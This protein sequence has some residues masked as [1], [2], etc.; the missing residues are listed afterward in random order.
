MPVDV[1]ILPQ[2]SG[3]PLAAPWRE[4][5]RLEDGRF[6]FQEERWRDFARQRARWALSGELLSAEIFLCLRGN[7]LAGRYDEHFIKALLEMARRH[8]WGDDI[9]LAV[10]WRNSIHR[11]QPIWRESLFK[12]FDAAIEH[13]ATDV[14]EEQIAADGF[15]ETDGDALSHG[16]K[17]S[18]RRHRALPL[19]AAQGEWKLVLP[20]TLSQEN[21]QALLGSFVH[22]GAEWREGTKLIAVV[23]Q[24]DP[25]VQSG[26]VRMWL[27]R[28]RRAPIVVA[29]SGYGVTPSRKLE[30]RCRAEDLELIEARGAF[31]LRAL[32][33]RHNQ[34]LQWRESSHGGKVE[35][36]KVDG[37]NR[38]FAA[39][40]QPGTPNLLLTSSFDPDGDGD[41][42]SHCLEASRDAGLITRQLPPRTIYLAHPGIRSGKLPEVLKFAAAPSGPPLTAWVFIGHGEGRRGLK[43]GRPDGLEK[44]ERWLN[45][46]KGYGRSLPLVIF[47]ACRS[48]VTAQHFARAGAGVAIGFE[49]DVPPKACQLLAAEVVRAA[50]CAGGDQQAIL[51]AFR[52][53]CQQL[54]SHNLDYANPTAYYGVG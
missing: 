45:R 44:P 8:C 53:G 32:L 2:G 47:A 10:N 17:L 19:V 5:D 30:E 21:L 41:E 29:L 22:Y 52:A 7:H 36:V 43:S 39:H 28:Y 3:Q 12:W 42:I 20:N 54:S 38:V 23:D 4:S 51:A 27:S 26:L 33:L 50:L 35:M 37:D 24:G 13:G 14:I 48:S 1:V 15:S 25:A 49:K 6:K 16:A 11:K 18:R 9:Y 31:E 34:S 40:R 46:F